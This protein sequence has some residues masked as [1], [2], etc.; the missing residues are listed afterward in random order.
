M[1]DSLNTGSIDRLI[2]FYIPLY[3]PHWNALLM[4]QNTHHLIVPDKFDKAAKLLSGISPS[5]PVE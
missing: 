5:G 4:L 1:V 3:I 2:G